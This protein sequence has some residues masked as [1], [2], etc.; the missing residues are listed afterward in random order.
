M[1]LGARFLMQCPMYYKLVISDISCL[2]DRTLEGILTTHCV[3]N[4]RTVSL[5]GQVLDIRLG[6]DQPLIS[7]Y[8]C[9]LNPEMA[10]VV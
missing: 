9:M 8:A 3:P 6:D 5:P 7:K 4:Y 1:E 2:A 10:T